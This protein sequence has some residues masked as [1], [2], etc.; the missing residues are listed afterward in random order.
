M[1]LPAPQFSGFR[2][3]CSALRKHNTA[4]VEFEKGGLTG[5]VNWAD[6][7]FQGI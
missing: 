5:V 1:M 4:S 6:Y 3:L 2:T 7:I